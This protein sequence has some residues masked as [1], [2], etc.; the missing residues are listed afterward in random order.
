M[1]VEKSK[2]MLLSHHQNAAKNHDVKV[3]NTSLENVSQLKYLGATLTLTT[4]TN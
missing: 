4:L 3:A 1:M 2:Y